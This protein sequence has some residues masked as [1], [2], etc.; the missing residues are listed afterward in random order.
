[1][2][3]STQ[4]YSLLIGEDI[5]MGGETIGYDKNIN[6]LE[7]E[8]EWRALNLNNIKKFSELLKKNAEI[9]FEVNRK[10]ENTILSKI[11]MELVES[12][13]KLQEE[14]KQGLDPFDKELRGETSLMEPCF[15]VAL[16]EIMLKASTNE[17]QITSKRNWLIFWAQSF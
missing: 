13:E 16:R 4:D 1:M 7:I 5:E 8:K 15:I 17:I 2:D 11:N 3:T 14:K 6:S 10:V 12:Q 9:I